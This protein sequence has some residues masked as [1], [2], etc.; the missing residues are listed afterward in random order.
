[1]KRKVNERHRART[2]I[3]LTPENRR[4][5]RE[6]AA[7]RREKGFSKIVDEAL[8]AYFASSLKDR[9]ARDELLA[10]KGSITDEEAAEMRA[11]VSKARK[12]WRR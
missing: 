2:T 1:M 7:E 9:A 3:E 4:R 6:L 10:L 8:D 11:N 12:S 5:L